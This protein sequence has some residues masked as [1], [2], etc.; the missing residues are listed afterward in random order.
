[1]RKLIFIIIIVILVLLSIIIA[2]RVR[3]RFNNLPTNDN[4]TTNGTL[5]D[6]VPPTGGSFA[7]APGDYKESI[8]V[9]GRER[10]YL[11]H[12]PTGFDAAKKYPLVLGFHGGN[13]TG[14][15]FARQ[16]GFKEKAD[17][18]GFIAVFPDGIENNW[19]DGRGTTDAEKQGVDDI[20]FLR[21]LVGRLQEKLPI[22]AKRIYATGVS[23]GGIFS[24]RLAC[25]MADVFAAT[26]PVIGSLATNYVA[27]CNP[28]APVSL[29]VIQGTEDPFI[30][31]E[32]GDTKH[33]RLGIGDGGLVESA[34]AAMKFWAKKNGCATSPTTVEP[35]P[36]VSDGTYYTL[37]QYK[38]CRNDTAVFYYVVHGMGHGWPPKGGEVSERVS[39]PT[40]QNINATDVIWEFFEGHTKK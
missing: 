33:K 24:H 12:I 1:M 20:K 18:E 13:G 25:D 31:I 8:T 4:Q 15:K 28:V 7:Y 35:R 36:A 19:N 22:D 27:K 29:V 37:Y 5:P 6:G 32:G 21:S 26:A 23:N 16:T 14:E 2:R 17:A 9:D 30:P 34:D 39:G 3:E 38:N 40:S 10:T 11:L